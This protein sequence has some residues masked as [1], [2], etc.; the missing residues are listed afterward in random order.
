MKQRLYLV[1]VL[2]ILIIAMA[3]CAKKG[4]PSGGAKD[5]IPPVITRTSP[6][7]F[8]INFNSDE[9]RV[10]FDEY[11]KLKDLQQNLIISP[12][13]KYDPIITPIGTSK[14]LRIKILDTLAPN[15]TYAIN[16]GRSI[17]D[18]NEE[19]EYDYYKYVFSTGDYIDSLAVNGKVKDALLPKVENPVTIMLHEVDS[20]FTDSVVFS[21][22]P[23]YVTT[24]RDSTGN[25]ELSNLKEGRYLLIALK[26]QSNDYTF[27]PKTDKIGFWAEELTLPTE[28]TFELT[29]FKEIPEFKLARPE[30]VSK[31]HIIFGYEG[32]GKELNVAPFGELP[33]GFESTTLRDIET[34]SLHY[35]FKPEVTTDSLL[36]I[37]RNKNLTDTLK[38]RMK[39]LYPDSLNVSGYKI[40][41]V[42]PA[43]TVSFRTSTPALSVDSELISIMDRDSV[44]LDFNTRISDK[45]L[46]EVIF[47]KTDDQRYQVSLQ[48]GAIT[49]Y[50]EAVS[51]SLEY[52][53]QTKALSDYGTLA[54]SLQNVQKLPIIVQ[55]V[56]EKFQ[57]TDEVYLTENS[58]VNFEYINPGRYYVRIVSDDN[59]NGKWDTGNFLEKIQPE[60]VKYYPR[61]LEIRANWSLNEIFRLD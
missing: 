46:V 16:F 50:Y 38:V 29:M 13:F 33:E 45:N 3:N 60:T 22:K 56:N 14:Q 47:D 25:F 9:I 2:L 30:H 36:F 31:Y 18:N 26:E 58:T 15:T 23:T 42:K 51:D 41:T 10:F 11:I 44:Q 55:L 48:P 28:E 43:D 24:T 37:A 6:E 17:V 34:D 53:I 8:S 21:E 54:L 20:T 39:N 40:G 1:P 32:D 57:V 5:T 49:D 35:W 52:V 12:P 19:N 7:N 59:S 4:N 61:Q 27:Q